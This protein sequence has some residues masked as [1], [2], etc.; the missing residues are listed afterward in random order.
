[1]GSET[2][3]VTFI[4]VRNLGADAL[5]GCSSIGKYIRNID[6]EAQTVTTS[7]WDEIPLVRRRSI[8]PMV[9]E[10]QEPK[11][12]SKKTVRSWNSVQVH[13]RTLLPPCSETWVN[14]YCRQRG[15]RIIE[16]APTKYSAKRIVLAN[17]VAKV[18]PKKP[19]SVRVANLGTHP[20]HLQRHRMIGY[21]VP[22]P[23][24]GEVEAIHF[25]EDNEEPIF[26]EP[27]GDDTKR[28]RVTHMNDG[29][30]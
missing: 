19:F 5:L 14:V 30:K 2:D 18:E 15:E 29:A 13:K 7:L 22:L 1:M 23:S 17:F 4:V 9:E 21:S 11:I 26:R 16:S 28:I 6:L 25:G 12:T 24:V 20:V 10:A 27:E 8:P 3:R